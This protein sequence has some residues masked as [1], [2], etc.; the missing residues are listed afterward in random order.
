MIASKL[1]F[2]AGLMAFSLPAASQQN[3]YQPTVQ[4]GD[5]LYIRACGPRFVRVRPDGKVTLPRVGDVMAAGLT[6]SEVAESL[7]PVCGKAIVAVSVRAIHRGDTLTISVR[8]VPELTTP[9][10]KVRPDG[11]I[12]LPLLGDMMVAGLTTRELA[13]KCKD[14]FAAATHRQNL[15]VEVTLI[16]RPAL[17]PLTD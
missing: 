15:L 12:T 13:D 1:L 7:R 14:E 3:E 10:I 6:T 5:T 17:I 9:A 8:Y 2:I 4:P 16:P 11:K